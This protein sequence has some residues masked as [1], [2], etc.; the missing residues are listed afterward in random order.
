MQFAIREGIPYAIDFMNPAPDMDVN[1]LGKGHFDWMVKT[2][3]D[4]MIELA[5]L[6]SKP[7][8]NMLG[9]N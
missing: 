4:V 2:M 3:A 1:S 8:T 6:M 7:V 9:V 5:L